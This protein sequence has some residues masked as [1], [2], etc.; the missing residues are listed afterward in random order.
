M[1]K[2]K[3]L[4]SY[5]YIGDKKYVQKFQLVTKQFTVDQTVDIE[6]K[7][8]GDMIFKDEQPKVV[9]EDIEWI[10]NQYYSNKQTM[11]KMTTGETIIK[12]SF[13]NIPAGKYKPRLQFVKGFGKLE[14]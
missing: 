8:N 4:Y 6:L 3:E 14:G 10:D 7:V 12:G 11:T 13:Q 5:K 2:D 1:Q 9:L